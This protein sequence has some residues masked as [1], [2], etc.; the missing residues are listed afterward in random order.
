MAKS[1]SRKKKLPKRR[2]QLHR[3]PLLRPYPRR[4]KLSK[5]GHYLDLRHV[6]A[7]M[8]KNE[9]WRCRQSPTCRKALS[10]CSS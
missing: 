5:F 7:Y 9:V 2:R 10:T 8:S 1:K 3:T 4:I 6:M